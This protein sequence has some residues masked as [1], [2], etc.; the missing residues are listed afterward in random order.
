MNDF[1]LSR[2]TGAGYDKGRPAVVQAM[3][4]A[5]NWTVLMRWWFPARL[6]PPVLR[7][8][9]AQIG[10][11]VLIRHDVKI[12]WPWKLTV[13]ADSWIGEGTWIIDLEPVTIG[14]D[15]CVSQGVL[16]CTGSHDRHSPGF[17]YDNAPVTI[18]D[19]VWLAARS[20]V[21]RG[22]TVGDGATVGATALVVRDVPPGAVVR[23]PIAHETSGGA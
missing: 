10:P 19:R 13:G 8:F 20:A 14:S 23:A 9:G 7:A 15:A 1:R 22:V 6:R 16:L 3:W 2:F 12:H 4:L 5:V 17:E 18:G 21:L 11:N